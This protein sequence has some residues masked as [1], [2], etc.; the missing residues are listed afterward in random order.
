M[1]CGRTAALLRRL[2]VAWGDA[3]KRAGV[4]VVADD[5]CRGDGDGAVAE[6]EFGSKCGINAEEGLR[7]GLCG[8]QKGRKCNCYTKIIGKMKVKESFL[9]WW[10]F[11]VRNTAVW[12]GEKGGFKAEFKRFTLEI[13][14]VSGNFKAGWT[15]DVYPYGYLLAAVKQGNEATLWGFC[16]RLYMWSK[17]LLC[18]QKLADDMDA[19][20]DGYSKRLEAVGED[21]EEVPEDAIL[22]YEKEVQ[23]L[24]ELKGKERRKR[25]KEID[26]KFKKILKGEKGE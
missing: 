21:A 16:E 24:S 1:G 6:V 26:A 19:A 25:E 7:F 13:R 17:C 8:E 3:E 23:E 9:K 11:K 10:Y 5:G 18:D 4:P 22:G 15:A 14:T 20:F 12:K 2:Q